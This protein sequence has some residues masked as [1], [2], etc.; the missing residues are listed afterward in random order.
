MEMQ[1]I[2]A[3]GNTGAVI[4]LSIFTFITFPHFPIFWQRPIINYK[5]RL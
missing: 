5:T 2:H 1:K 4:L 3:A